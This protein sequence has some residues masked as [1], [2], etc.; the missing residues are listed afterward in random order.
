MAR[1]KG[2]DAS[3]LGDLLKPYPS[4]ETLPESL[5][6]KLC[7]ADYRCFGFRYLDLEPTEKENECS[8]IFKD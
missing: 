8:E 4:V 1:P 7:D 6:P 5:L 2:Q 3:K